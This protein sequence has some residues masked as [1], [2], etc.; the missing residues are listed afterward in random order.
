MTCVSDSDEIEDVAVAVAPGALALSHPAT[1]LL[2]IV[3]DNEATSATAQTPQTS[4]NIP[5]CG[6]C[7][8]LPTHTCSF[9][10]HRLL[11]LG[12]GCACH[13]KAC[14]PLVLGCAGAGTVTGCPEASSGAQEHAPTPCMAGSSVHACIQ[15]DIIGGI[16]EHVGNWPGSSV[17]QTVLYMPDSVPELGERDATMIFEAAAMPAPGAAHPTRLSATRPDIGL[18]SSG[19]EPQG[20]LTLS[21]AAVLAPQLLTSKSATTML[22]VL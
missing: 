9:T 11:I 16:V 17:V 6:C 7:S 5:F 20:P 12:D 4:E 3:Q 2:A 13:A 14:S 18:T 8:G 1:Y 22:C 10:R 21:H 15:P 19:K